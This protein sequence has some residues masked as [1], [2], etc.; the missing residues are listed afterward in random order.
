MLD[1][2]HALVA[3]AVLMALGATAFAAQVR[4]EPCQGNPGTAFGLDGK[5]LGCG[6][7]VKHGVNGRVLLW[8]GSVPV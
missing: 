1:A 4:R 8:M 2:P 3:Q 5:E 7:A 6:V